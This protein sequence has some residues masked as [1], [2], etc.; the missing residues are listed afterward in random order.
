MIIHPSI[1]HPLSPVS[2]RSGELCVDGLFPVLGAVGLRDGGDPGG[3][4]D[5]GVHG[6]LRR[7]HVGEGGVEAGAL[8]GRVAVVGAGVLVVG[9]VVLR[10]GDGRV[11]GAVVREVEGAVGDLL[12]RRVLLLLAVVAGAQLL[13]LDVRALGLARLAAQR[14]QRVRLRLRGRGRL[15]GGR[16]RRRLLRGR[17]RGLGGL[18]GL[19]RGRLLL[20]HPHVARARRGRRRRRRRAADA[21]AAG[22]GDLAVRG[23][24]PRVAVGG[25]VLVKLVD[26]E[27]LDVGD[28]VAAQLA[29]VHVA[30]V[31]GGLSAPLGQGAPLSLQVSLAGLHVGFGGGRWRRWALG[32]PCRQQKRKR[33]RKIS[34]GC[35]RTLQRPS[36][37]GKGSKGPRIRKGG[38]LPWRCD[39]Q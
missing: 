3:V 9:V 36:L 23:R 24:H 11:G 20:G 33:R 28:D 27:G 10:A 6:P 39:P 26:V 29:D 38:A 34:E 15:L 13:R 17:R 2:S 22:V 37:A 8:A 5:G 19:L 4:G 16:G 21:V 30:E 25:Q 12:R 7:V 18:R 14:G 1:H 31:D 32:L 35:L